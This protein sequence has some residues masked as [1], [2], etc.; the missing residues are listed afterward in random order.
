M[1]YVRVESYSE[2]RP[3]EVDTESSQTAVYLRKNIDTV[4][5]EEG[6]GTH[7]IY[8][9][10]KLKK[11]QYQNYLDVSLVV[12]DNTDDAMFDLAQM[13]DENSQAIMELAEML[14]EKEE[15]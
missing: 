7:W 11:E 12:E 6:E 13:I 8:D 10:L 3:L 14:E 15:V 9:E 1:Q 2:T 5:N 4:P